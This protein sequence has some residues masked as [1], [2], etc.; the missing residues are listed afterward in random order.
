M[1]GLL[2]IAVR[3]S[4][5]EPGFDAVR[6]GSPDF[7]GLI[8][9]PVK[10]R[11]GGIAFACIRTGAKPP[12]N[13]FDVD[14]QLLRDVLGREISVV[15]NGTHHRPAPE[16]AGMGRENFDDFERQEMLRIERRRRTRSCLLRCGC[17]GL[18]VRQWI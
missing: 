1:R 9:R 8:L 13:A 6:I 18:T 10:Q 12:E 16:T 14:L 15:T 7:A 2:F 3:R 5:F 4:Q 11:I 17:E